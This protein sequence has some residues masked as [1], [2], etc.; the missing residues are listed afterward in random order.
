MESRGLRL[1]VLFVCL[2]AVYVSATS[3]Y[4]TQSGAGGRN[5]TSLANA[6]SV[7][8]YNASST[9]TGGD[10]VYFSGTLT[11][12]VVPNTSG[13]SG[14]ILTLDFSAATLTPPGISF[15]GNNYLTMTGGTFSGGTDGVSLIHCTSTSGHITIS[16]FTFTAASNAGTDAFVEATG[17]CSNFV[18][19]GN[20]ATYISSCVVFDGGHVDTWD[21]A[22][23]L[24]VSNN[25][26]TNAQTDMLFIPDATN[27]TIEGNKI[28][29]QAP[30]QSGCC[31][32]DGIQTFKSGAGGAVNPS[33]FVIRY[34]W[35][36]RNVPA[37]GS[38]DN[39]WMEIENMSGQ[40][41]MKIYSNV[42][43]GETPN[44]SG[45]NGISIHS[46]TNAS[47]TYY[48]YNNTVYRHQQP[49]NAIRLGEGDGPGT[50]YWRN[51]VAAQD[52]SCNC[53]TTQATFS[54]GAA[55]DYNYFS[56]NWDTCNSSFTGSHG[57]CSAV[58]AFVNSSSDNFELQ[59]GSTLL[60]AGDSSIGNEFNQ[61]IAYNAT[62][63]NPALAA[64][65]AGAWDIGAYQYS[66]QDPPAP[67]SQLTAV[68]Y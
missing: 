29:N 57:T 49:G 13:S 43:V 18:V 20:S 26:I 21:I 15:G 44:I 55:W 60:S 28:I 16:N 54:A 51:N 35:I 32:N 30:G 38:G 39:S 9:P 50:L 62:W 10:T 67:P 59:P 3:Y 37:G 4:V 56:S 52:S 1:S 36:E 40:P 68:P 34:N 64:R 47:D 19:S 25:V 31:H 5:G 23:N 61:G 53:T 7:A 58:P 2:S 27:I 6:W 17:G 22:N 41:A 65:T 45:G 11:S 12:T 66:T 14:N 24:C 46:G 33:N 42:F 48:F 63:P 8:N